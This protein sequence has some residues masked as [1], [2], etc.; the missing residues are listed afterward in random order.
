MNKQRES[1]G[2]TVNRV[3]CREI[4]Q[5]NHHRLRVKQKKVT[6][7][8]VEPRTYDDGTFKRSRRDVL[9]YKISYEKGRVT[10]MQT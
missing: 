5:C 8:E 6:S 2:R 1:E 4:E 7:E 10:I 3:S 9:R